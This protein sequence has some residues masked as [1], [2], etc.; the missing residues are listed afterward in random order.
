M[1]QLSIKT[2][3]GVSAFAL[4]TACTGTSGDDTAYGTDTYE[5]TEMGDTG[6]TETMD[7]TTVVDIAAGNPDFST[8]VTAVT[9]AELV[10]TLN[11]DGPFTV[12]AP[13]NA[14]FDALPDGTVASLLEDENQSQLQGILT[15]HVVP[16]NVMASDLIKLI[17]MNDGTAEVT[18]VQGGTLK[19]MLDGSNVKLMDEMGNTAMVTGTDIAA[20]NGVVHVIDTVIMPSS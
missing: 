15:Y 14:A 2:L 7:V 4:A 18:T 1:T 9:E 19:A 8:L 5:T 10:D 17:N 6:T 20:S 13:T 11:G 12:F 16:G 3:L